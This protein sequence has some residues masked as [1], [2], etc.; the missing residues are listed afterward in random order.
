MKMMIAIFVG[1]FLTCA[2]GAKGQAVVDTDKVNNYTVTE[3]AWFEVEVKDYLGP[4][5]P[6]KGRFEIALFGDSA[7]MTVMNFVNIVKGYKRGKVMNFVD[8]DDYDNDSDDE[9]DVAAD[10]DNDTY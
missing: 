3:E 8:Y 10:D 5:Q 1:Y 9:D 2:L 6:F 4:G 7:P